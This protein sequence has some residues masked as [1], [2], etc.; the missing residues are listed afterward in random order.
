M[1]RQRI[2]QALKPRSEIALGSSTPFFSAKMHDAAGSTTVAYTGRDFSGTDLSG[3]IAVSGTTTSIFSNPGE[4]TSAGDNGTLLDASLVSLINELFRTDTA[5]TT[6]VFTKCSRGA[7]T[8]DGYLFGYN[9]FSVSGYGLRYLTAS[10]RPQFIYRSASGTGF[11]LLASSAMDTANTV[12]DVGVMLHSDTTTVTGAIAVNGVQE[13]T[14]TST[15]ILT[16]SGNGAALFAYSNGA[17]TAASEPMNPG[18][19]M[20]E[21]LILKSA[22]DL[23]AEFPTIASEMAKVKGDLVWQL[24]G[25]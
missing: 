5:G 3:T 20:S 4:F 22:Q 1:S 10:G 16:P 19:R 18:V 11:T 17:G 7:T 12:I 6:L 25:V 9:P 8:N 15:D 24:D 2:V 23:S 21:L 14:N 13:N